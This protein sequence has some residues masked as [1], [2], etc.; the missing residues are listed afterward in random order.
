[1][2]MKNRS[3]AKKALTG[4]VVAL[5]GAYAEHLLGPVQAILDLFS[6]LW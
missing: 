6:S 1:M 3:K 5:V 2:D 4:V